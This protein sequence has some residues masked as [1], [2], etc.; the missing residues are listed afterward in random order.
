M[1]R[2]KAS[3]NFWLSWHWWWLSTLCF[4][5]SS[6]GIWRCF[7]RRRRQDLRRLPPSTSP[8]SNSNSNSNHHLAMQKSYTRCSPRNRAG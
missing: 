4:S 6:P 1:G 3:L 8:S 7:R 5:S 2:R